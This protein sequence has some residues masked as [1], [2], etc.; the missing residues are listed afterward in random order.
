MRIA[1][2][3][4]IEG[5]KAGIKLTHEQ[6]E[7]AQAYYELLEHWNQKINLTRVR[8]PLEWTRHHFLESVYAAQFIPA[9]C[10]RHLDIGTGAGFPAIP[11]KLVREDLIPTWVEAR[12]RKAVFLKQVIRALDLKGVD[13]VVERLE[14]FV[15]DLPEITRMDLVTLRAINVPPSVL[16]DLTHRLKNGSF[17][18]V[19]H[20][21]DSAMIR[22]MK[23]S[24]ALRKTRHEHLPFSENRSLSM[25]HVEH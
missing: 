2:L 7:K 24:R 9:A 3:I 20:G 10:R 21:T 16:E 6:L 15:K 13:V 14:T 11:L 1:E 23:R 5:D 18:A 12:K 22:E 25:F 4:K 17:V 8:H 19:W